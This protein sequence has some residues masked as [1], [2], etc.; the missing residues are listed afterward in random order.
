MC[1]LPMKSE[2]GVKIHLARMHKAAKEKQ[3]KGRLADKAVQT[4]K[5]K[6]AVGIL[7][8]QNRTTVF[9]E[10]EPLENV[11]KCIYLGTLFAVDGEQRYDI[12]RGINLAK[13]R[14]GK[15]SHIFDHLNLSLSLHLKL[16]M[17]IPG[18]CMFPH[19]VRMRN[20]TP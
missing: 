10:G 8:Q 5:D 1:E 11:F 6:L 12:T 20:L 9:C 4:Q 19:N 2:R 16:R 14:C 17:H 7:Q 15:L 3:F 13:A 18:S